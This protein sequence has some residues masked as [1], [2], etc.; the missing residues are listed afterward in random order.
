L[1]HTFS[2]FFGRELTVVHN[3]YQPYFH[4]SDDGFRGLEFDVLNALASRFNFT[5]KF[6]RVA[7]EMWGSVLPNGSWNGMV[8]DVVRGE[9]DLAMSG[10][11]ITASRQ[12]AV[13][14]TFPIW[15]EP[16]CVAIK[17]YPNNYFYF[18]DPFKPM[19]WLCWLLLPVMMGISAITKIV[20]LHK[21]DKRPKNARG[22]WMDVVNEV[23]NYFRCLFNQGLPHSVNSTYAR[24][25]Q[26]TFWLFA[27]VVYATYGGNL[28]A[29][30][31]APKVEWPFKD[32]E[33]L[34]ENKDY[35]VIVTKGSSREELFTGNS[36]GVYQRI[37]DK[38]RKQETSV[39]ED[40]GAIF[41]L[42]RTH[43][44][45][46][47]S[48]L[49]SIVERITTTEDCNIVILSEMFMPTGIGIA[50]RKGAV[51]KRHFDDV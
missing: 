21:T 31:A 9:A 48:D 29:S 28:A 51:Y 2:S 36:S 6:Y 34:A 50:M 24:I 42:M 12:E 26:S 20:P 1:S 19:V 17:L 27:I 47:S 11:S 3:W 49:S 45:A 25:I 33:G 41:E 8:G 46:Y 15:T 18:I 39:R 14:F 22:L 13:D 32:L 5:Y 10:I 37:A 30:L 7:D 16:S 38:M 40:G 35:D 44:I 43:K 23:F 4:N